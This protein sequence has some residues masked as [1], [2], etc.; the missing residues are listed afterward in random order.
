MGGVLDP[1]PSYRS[2]WSKWVSVGGYGWLDVDV[3]PAR[4]VLTFRSETG[5]SRQSA[6]VGF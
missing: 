5:E 6:T 2:P 3:L 4:L 1:A